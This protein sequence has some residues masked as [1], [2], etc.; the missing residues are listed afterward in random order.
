M[1]QQQIPF[2]T[3][4]LRFWEDFSIAKLFFFEQ[5]TFRSSISLKK[6]V[7]AHCALYRLLFN[8]K[9]YRVMRLITLVPHIES[10][11]YHSFYT[12]LVKHV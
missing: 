2:F 4:S 5:E 1:I 12:S 10:S 6:K 3:F 9:D 11:F 8:M 7:F